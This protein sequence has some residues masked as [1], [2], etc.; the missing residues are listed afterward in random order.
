MQRFPGT[1]QFGHQN[2]FSVFRPERISNLRTSARRDAPIGL[3]HFPISFGSQ[4]SGF[5]SATGTGF[6]PFPYG[7]FSP[8]LCKAMKK[9]TVLLVDDHTVVRE[10]LRALLA[11]EEDIEVV[12]E[13][14][15]GRRA[16]ALAKQLLPEV[17][18]MDGAMP[19]LNGMD[20]TRQILKNCKGMAV[21]VI[22]SYTDEEC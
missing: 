2:R 5:G 18:V 9:I 3:A 8:Y 4:Y 11:Q 1:K 19:L 17:V 6:T 13:A 21:L 10:G 20:A 7:P 22:S 14:A 12:G 16:L 15:D